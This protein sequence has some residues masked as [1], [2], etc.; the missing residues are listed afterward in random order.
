MRTQPMGAGYP[1]SLP[2]FQG[3]L[4]LLLQLIEQKELDI[5][6][7]SLVA[8]TD[9]YL[10]AIEQMAEREA[11]ALADFLVVASKLLLIKSRQLLPRPQTPAQGEEED[12]SDALIQQL[13]QY[14]QFKAVAAGLLERQTLGLRS[15]LRPVAP[16]A[17][18]KQL[19]LSNV[20]LATL[21]ALLHRALQRMP[22]EMPTPRVKSYPIT[23]AEQMEV[24]RQRLRRQ[25]AIQRDARLSFGALL[26][27]QSTRLEV[28]VTF[29][30]VLELI[31][32][33]EVWAVQE[34]LFGEIV[35]AP[36]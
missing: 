18:T 1:V 23:V 27:E 35:L 16:V 22:G 9:Q 13:L 4:A 29:L 24:V 33:Q 26:N 15:Y 30:A 5:N 31:K 7:I 6:T 10:R 12:P 25:Q 19:D 32:Q 2:A 28:I 36:P 21:G 17:V 8:V 11:G 20:D 14:R 34:Q 3:P